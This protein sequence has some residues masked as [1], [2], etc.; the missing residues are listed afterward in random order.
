MRGLMI[1]RTP[2]IFGRR[3]ETRK[4]TAL[5]VQIV[6]PTIVI[7]PLTA[8][9]VAVPGLAQKS[10]T[11]FHGTPRYF[12]STPL[13]SPTS[14]LASRGWEAILSGFQVNRWELRELLKFS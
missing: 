10:K 9:T 6:L 7:L 4:S 14:A 12:M 3:I 5:G 2:E 1:G 11:G 8:I 13:C